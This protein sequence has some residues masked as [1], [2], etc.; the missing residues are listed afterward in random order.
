[1]GKIDEGPG[2]ARRAAK[3]REKKEPRKEENEDVSA[4][5]TRIR[6]PLGVFVQIGRRNSL[7]V[8]IRH[9]SKT[10]EFGRY[11]FG[12]RIEERRIWEEGRSN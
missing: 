9:E 10:L 2:H 4:P 3:N 7:D 11:P 8:Q 1:M 6:E 5:H 12:R